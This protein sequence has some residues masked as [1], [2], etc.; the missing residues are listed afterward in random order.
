MKTSMFTLQL[1]T[2]SLCF[3]H[4]THF[5]LLSARS[6]EDFFYKI[7]MCPYKIKFHIKYINNTNWV[8]FENKYILH[9]A[10]FCPQSVYLPYISVH[11]TPQLI[12]SFMQFVFHLLEWL[13]IFENHLNL[14]LLIDSNTPICIA[15][16]NSGWLLSY[17]AMSIKLTTHHCHTQHTA[18]IKYGEKCSCWLSPW[19]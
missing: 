4:T 13:W 15:P 19:L 9:C 11:K 10:P 8:P 16:C 3:L 12:R 7:Q 18:R 17:T 5:S 14:I 2:L 6:Q 1:H